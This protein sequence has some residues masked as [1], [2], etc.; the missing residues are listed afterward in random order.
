MVEPSGGNEREIK[1]AVRVKATGDVA[2]HLRGQCADDFL[3]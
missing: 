1:S 3:V 2:A